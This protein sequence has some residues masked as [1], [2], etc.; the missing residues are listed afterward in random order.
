M[1][2]YPGS[3]RSITAWLEAEAPERAPDRVLT[4]ARERIRTTQQR[5]LLWPVRRTAHMN[6]YAKLAIAAAAVLVVAVVGLNLM[7]V[8]G[9]PGGPVATP[10]PVPS[11]TPSP[12]PTASPTASPTPLAPFPS[13]GLLVAGR[14]TAVLEGVPLSFDLTAGWTATRYNELGKGTFARPDGSLF[15]FWTS[16]PDNVYAD[17]CAH[18]P[19]SEPIAPSPAGFAAAVSTLRGTDIVTPPTTV[20]IDGHQGVHVAIRIRDDI[21]C[22][23]A[24]FYRW[25]DD[26]T[27]GPLGGYRDA[28]ALGAT[29][30]AW[31]IEVDG[32]RVWIDGETYAGADPSV[33][34]E[35]QRIIESIR[36][37]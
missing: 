29:I 32:K 22:L 20:T 16:S 6:A 8:G 24:N 34:Q 19:L 18:T 37:S 17:P 7:P 35:Q 11:L 1:S 10:T 25:Y 33:G 26:A 14:H 30:H 3:D 5:R 28:S 13:A 31:I 21:A 4:A 2:S 27:G 15:V 12:A 9:G 36:F 23:P